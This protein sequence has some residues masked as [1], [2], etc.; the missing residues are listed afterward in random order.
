[1]KSKLEAKAAAQAEARRAAGKPVS[2]IEKTLPKIPCLGPILLKVYYVWDWFSKT[3]FWHTVQAFLN[4]MALLAMFVALANLAAAVPFV[5]NTP[6]VSAVAQPDAHKPASNELLNALGAA[7]TNTKLANT[8]YLYAYENGKSAVRVCTD[9]TKLEFE[10][11]TKVSDYEKWDAM[12]PSQIKKFKANGC[13]NATVLAYNGGCTNTIRFSAPGGSYNFHSVPKNEGGPEAQKGRCGTPGITQMLFSSPQTPKADGWL[14]HNMLR[15]VSPIDFKPTLL[16]NIS[17]TNSSTCGAA[18]CM[19]DACYDRSATCNGFQETTSCGGNYTTLG[20]MKSCQTPLGNEIA[21]PG[22]FNSGYCDCGN[23]RKV[24]M[25]DKYAFDFKCEDTCKCENPAGDTQPSCPVTDRCNCTEVEV[26]TGDTQPSWMENNPQYENNNCIRS[27][28]QFN[29]VDCGERTVLSYSFQLNWV[30]Q[31]FTAATVLRIILQVAFMYWAIVEDEPNYRILMADQSIFILYFLCNC[32]SHGVKKVNDALEKE[33][34]QGWP[35]LVSLVD[36]I[37][38]TVAVLGVAYGA[39]PFP[40]VARGR[41]ELLLL[42]IAAFKETGKL[43]VKLYETIG[44]K[45]YRQVGDRGVRFPLLCCIKKDIP[46]C[47]VIT[48]EKFDEEK[49]SKKAAVELKLANE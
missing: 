23:N 4:Y 25:C 42:W 13:I 34:F 24:W 33:Y 32:R 39:D 9:L 45:A 37:L 17:C 46:W 1:M 15:D 31:L 22:Q 44:K 35:W 36:S 28:G 41:M 27:Y 49:A 6:V 47:V 19:D 21:K 11:I 20:A 48:Q 8:K 5:E 30:V 43:A 38:V 26:K 2:F 12:N 14:W 7:S 3:T 40:G 10:E 29:L 16:K 18:K